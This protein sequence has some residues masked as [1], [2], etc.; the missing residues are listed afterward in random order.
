MAQMRG[1][2]ILNRTFKN[3]VNTKSN[4]YFVI[5]RDLKTLINYKKPLKNLYSPFIVQSYIFLRPLCLHKALLADE[6]QPKVTIG[7]ADELL[8]SKVSDESKGESESKQK[9]EDD[10]DKTIRALKFSFYAFGIMLTGIGSFLF[11]SWGKFY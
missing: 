10:K 8:A 1:L 9:S 7:L 11:Y 6:K 4:D 3:S 2:W 5:K